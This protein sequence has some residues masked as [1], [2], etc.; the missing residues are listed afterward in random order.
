M[1]VLICAEVGRQAA[2]Y[3][4]VA[5]R[6]RQC[7]PTEEKAQQASRALS[8]PNAAPSSDTQTASSRPPFREIRVL[9]RHRSHHHNISLPGYRCATA[10]ADPV[11]GEVGASTLTA[12]EVITVLLPF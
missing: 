11:I 12:N 5:E 2:A 8:A 10:L 9:D 3:T 6:A 4:K 7:P 1:A